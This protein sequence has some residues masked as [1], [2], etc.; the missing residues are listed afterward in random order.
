[1]TFVLILIFVLLA[2]A[3]ASFAVLPGVTSRAGEKVRGWYLGPVLGAAVV[4]V[5]GLGLYAM[6]GQPALALLTLAPP[7]DEEVQQDWPILISR[8]AEKMREEPNDPRGWGFLGQ[9]YLALGQTELSVK[10]YE[11]AIAV[12]QAQGRPVS[13]EILSGYGV[14]LMQHNGDLTA[15]AEDL[16]RQ[17]LAADPNNQDARYHLGLAHALRHEDD[18]AIRL[19]DPL[20]SEASPGKEWRG[21]MIEQLAILKARAAGGSAPDPRVMVANL[22]KRL[23]ANPN[24]LDGWLMLIRSYGFL[25]EKEKAHQAWATARATFAGD[26]A[27]LA[28]L[29]AQAREAEVE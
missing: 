29:A 4:L 21:P 12:S 24:D 6:T 25:G 15:D 2:L 1:M 16:F 18:A 7:S 10:A 3:A 27:A 19:W 13:G 26:E 14:A 9:G 5:G 8:L 11:R 22:A 28:A 20:V 23:E 17:A